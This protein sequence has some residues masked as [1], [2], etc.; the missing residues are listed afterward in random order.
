MAM[1]AGARRLEIVQWLIE[2]LHSAKHEELGRLSMAQHAAM[3]V[4]IL[5][6][7]RSY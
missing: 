7:L 6:A 1:G 5:A 4:S 2:G 3:F